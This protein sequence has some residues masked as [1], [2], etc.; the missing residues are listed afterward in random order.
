VGIVVPDP[1]FLS[2]W[3]KK[4]GIE[5]SYTEMCKCKVNHVH[6]KKIKGTICKFSPPEV[7]F[8]KQ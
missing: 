5:G 1:D 3:A 7:A 6:R 2:G 4:R 8:S